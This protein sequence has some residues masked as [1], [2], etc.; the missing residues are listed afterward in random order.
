MS[1]PVLLLEAE[2]DPF[3]PK[4][5]FEGYEELFPDAQLKF[6]EGAAHFWPLEK[7]KEV[8][9]IIKAFLKDE[10]IK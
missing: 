2:L 10:K 9:K 7:P 1:F 8:T 3:Q 5:Y 4:Y 6:I